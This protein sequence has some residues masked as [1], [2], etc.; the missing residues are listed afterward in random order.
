[1]ADTDDQCPNCGH[2]RVVSVE[3]TEFETEEVPYSGMLFWKSTTVTVREVDSGRSRA[4]THC[5][6][7]E[8]YGE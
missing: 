8:R 6:W 7:R 2:Y 5:G 4:C 1:V 3:R